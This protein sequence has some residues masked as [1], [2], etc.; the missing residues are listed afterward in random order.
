MIKKTKTMTVREKL[1]KVLKRNSKPL[2]TKVLAAK[3]GVNYNSARREL[4]FLDSVFMADR[5]TGLSSN[6][7]EARWVRTKLT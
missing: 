2:T 6:I 7:N 1:L 3:A 4:R 5:L